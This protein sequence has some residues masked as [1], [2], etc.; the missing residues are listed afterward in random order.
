MSYLDVYRNKLTINGDTINGDREKT[1]AIFVDER[2]NDSPSYKIAKL[3]KKDLSI[4]DVDI[5]VVNEDK[6]IEKK[7]YVSHSYMATVGDYITYTDNGVDLKCLIYD[8]EENLTTACCYSKKCN[9]TLKLPSGKEYPCVVSNDSYGS[10]TNLN[11]EFIGEVDTKAKIEL[12]ANLN[13]LVE[14]DIDIRYMFNKSKFDIY[15]ATDIQTSIKNG[16]ITIICKKDKFLPTLDKTECNYCHQ[17]NNEIIKP[18]VT[19]QRIVG[20]EVIPLLTPQIYKL[21]SNNNCIFTLDEASLSN[22]VAEII[23]VT[24]NSIS[25]Q[26]LKSGQVI[27]INSVI[28]GILVDTYDVVT[29]KF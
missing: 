9:E 24:S 26:A 25:I 12:Q 5:R 16:I 18:T 14:C 3:H 29:S 20:A 15:K 6:S 8:V 10:K 28:N 27:T 17:S 11:N 7:I 2:F 21:E 22:G 19:T 13:T 4:I 23:S 1:T